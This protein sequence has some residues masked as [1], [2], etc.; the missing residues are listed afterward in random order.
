MAYGCD[1]YVVC[2]WAPQE[3]HQVLLEIQDL[4]I[5]LKVLQNITVEILNLSFLHQT[6]FRNKVLQVVLYMKQ[7]K[8]H[9]LILWEEEKKN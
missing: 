5:N 1:G 2:Y 7:E 6:L 3:E 9:I 4:S 8:N